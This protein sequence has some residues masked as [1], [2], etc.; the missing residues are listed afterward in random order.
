MRIHPQR[1]I[2]RLPIIGWTVSPN[3]Y[4]GVQKF[5]H[6]FLAIFL[7][8]ADFRTIGELRRR[9]SRLLL[10]EISDLDLCFAHR[11]FPLNVAFGWYIGT[12]YSLAHT[13]TSILRG[14]REA[15]SVNPLLKFTNRDER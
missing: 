10:S 3:G 13:L 5:G 11:A 4:I 1:L 15:D 7:M 9:L 6:S 8:P 2:I 14:L 12:D